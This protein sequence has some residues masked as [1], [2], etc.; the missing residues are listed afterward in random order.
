MH[1]LWVPPHKGSKYELEYEAVWTI[2]L[3]EHCNLLEAN[4]HK[5]ELMQIQVVFYGRE[6]IQRAI[7]E[8]RAQVKAKWAVPTI[9]D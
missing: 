1:E 9:P 7:E 5:R 8:A 3:C 2:L 6:V 4:S